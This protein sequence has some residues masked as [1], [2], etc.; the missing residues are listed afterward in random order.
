MEHIK[1][2]VDYEVQAQNQSGN[3]EGKMEF[4]W[5]GKENAPDSDWFGAHK[6]LIKN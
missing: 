2:P 1:K 4:S 3:R 6:D 5:T